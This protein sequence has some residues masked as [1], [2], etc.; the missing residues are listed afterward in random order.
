MARGPEKSVAELKTIKQLTMTL[1]P[2]LFAVGLDFAP[3]A[4]RGYR[5]ADVLSVRDKHI[6]VIDPIFDG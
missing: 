2:D 5:F 3:R 6:V 1:Y 4:E